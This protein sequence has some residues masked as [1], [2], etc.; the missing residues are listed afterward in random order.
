M[1]HRVGDPLRCA[2]AQ[3]ADY[4]SERGVAFIEDDKIDALAAMIGSFLL[5][6]DITAAG[7]FGD[8]PT[9]ADGPHLDPPVVW[10]AS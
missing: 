4:L 7:H 6:A 1:S 3:V 8:S 2:A 5:A 10:Q 9:V